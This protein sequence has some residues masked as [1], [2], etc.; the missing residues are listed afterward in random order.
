MFVTLSAIS[1]VIRNAQFYDRTDTPIPFFTGVN[2]VVKG[3]PWLPNSEGTTHCINEYTSGETCQSFSKHD[4]A[5]LKA[6]SNNTFNAIRLSVMWS[7]AQPEDMDDI[8][9]LIASRLPEEHLEE[10]FFTKVLE[11][12]GF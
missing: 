10:P 7:G 2:I 8:E 6:T 5:Y 1:L 12:F 3:P 11:F 9:D 4:I